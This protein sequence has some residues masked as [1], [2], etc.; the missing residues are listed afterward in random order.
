MDKK[1][2]GR[3]DE[4]HLFLDGIQPED[5]QQGELGNCYFLSALSAITEHPER[6]QRLFVNS[7]LNEAGVYGVRMTKNGEKLQVI[8]DSYIPCLNQKPIFST[9]NG[10]ELWVII[11]E[12]AWAKVHGSYEVIEGGQ[13]VDVFRD[14]LG[15]P[16]YDLDISEEGALAAIIEADH[17]EYVMAASINTTDSA[18]LDELRVRG[19]VGNH[20]YS[21]IGYHK[22]QDDD[23]T[24]VYLMQ[25]R[26][27]W[28]RFEWRG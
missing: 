26:N 3:D 8:V 14:L 5:V 6:I 27:P 10:N 4:V 19:L 15:A 16:A 20:A 17:N 25:L 9:G 21:L 28:G 1:G 13:C 2:R 7:T 12:K 23:G 18:W 22:V 11:L 24:D